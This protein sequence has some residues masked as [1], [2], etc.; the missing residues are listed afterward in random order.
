MK[1]IFW[2]YPV[3]PRFLWARPSFLT[4][5]ARGLDWIIL[6]GWSASASAASMPAQGRQHNT[7]SHVIGYFELLPPRKFVS[8][9]LITFLAVYQKNLPLIVRGI[10]KV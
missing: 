9:H 7:D 2:G 3:R 1:N 10:F 8:I 6:I 5:L 4:D